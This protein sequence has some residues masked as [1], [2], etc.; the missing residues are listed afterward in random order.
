ML[1][2][3]LTKSR[4]PLTPAGVL[5]SNTTEQIFMLS[6]QGAEGVFSAPFLFMPVNQRPIAV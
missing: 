4:E 1:Y 2:K 3:N 5:F 6:P